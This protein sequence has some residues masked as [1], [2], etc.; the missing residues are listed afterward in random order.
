M[1]DWELAEASGL[2]DWS[3]SYQTVGQFMSTDL[4]TLRPTDLVDLAASVMDWRHIRH[5]P[6]EDDEGGL[7]GLVTHRGLLRLMSNRSV[8]NAKK[9]LTVSEIMVSNPT[10]VT[11]TTPTL[12][13]MEIMR[14]AKIGCLPVVDDGQL[15]GIVTSYDFLTA[16]ARLFKK[17]LKHAATPLVTKAAARTAAG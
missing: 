13:A 9:A 6:V 16:T 11:S 7:A 14:L 12:E 5:V 8:S 4:F 3:Q 17:H 1:H 2:D 15:V 10:S